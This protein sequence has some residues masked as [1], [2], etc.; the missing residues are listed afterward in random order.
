MPKSKK[1]EALT[2][3][4]NQIRADPTS[5][6]GLATLEEVLGSKHSIA[7]AQAAKL[8]GEAEI[9]ALVP[10][11]VRTFDRLM[12]KAADRDPGCRAKAEI[13]DCLYRLEHRDA[14]LFLQG[15]RHVQ[16]EPV[17]GGQVDTAPKLR[18]LCALGL[19][20]MNYPDV[21]V[22]LA[23]L[24]ADPEPE[25]R[26]GAARAIAYSENP[27]GVALL[28]LRIQVGDIPAVLG[29][30]VAALLQ[31][32]VEYCLPLATAFLDAGRRESDALEAIETAEVVALVLG[33]S[34][35]PEALPLLQTW[36]K[37]STHPELRQSGL[38]AI[39]MLRRDE[40]IQWLLQLLADAP[41]KDAASA[42]EALGLYQHDTALWS[43]VRATLDQRPELTDPG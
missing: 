38:L 12:E 21:M 2:A 27:L 36:W 11:L 25:A 14:D 7:I 34:R 35:R 24:L 40:A 22:E 30:C 28:R 18:G 17:W 3:Q 10:P 37:R 9:H 42:L 1:L 31:L 6:L 39:A 43:Q 15:V 4:L 5:E 32:S 23:D 29:E 33:E 8:I 13:A 20:R 26:I 41:K 16:M 19:V